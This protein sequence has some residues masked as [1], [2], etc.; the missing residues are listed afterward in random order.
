[1][2]VMIWQTIYRKPHG[3]RKK[4]S[5][6]EMMWKEYCVCHVSAALAEAHALSY[7]NVATASKRVG[8][9]NLQLSAVVWTETQS[10]SNSAQLLAQIDPVSLFQWQGWRVLI[11]LQFR[12]E[13]LERPCRWGGAGG[14][15]DRERG[16]RYDYPWVSIQKE[17]RQKVPA[18]LENEWF[19]PHQTCGSISSW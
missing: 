4:M 2:P 9:R 12:E 19:W 16:H 8:P 14:V 17:K 3:R 15:V 10:P 18:E 1:M 6:L 7:G 13:R 11:P 5:V